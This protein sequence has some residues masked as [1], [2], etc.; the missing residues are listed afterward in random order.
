[1]KKIL[2]LAV[3]AGVALL[4]IWSRP[5]WNHR[6]EILETERPPAP[7]E[8]PASV[9]PQETAPVV[10][11]EPFRVGFS[12]RETG[13]LG[14]AITVD[15]VLEADPKTLP[16]GLVGE[17]AALEYLLRLPS[18]VQLKSDGWA[19]VELPPEEKDDPTGVWNLFERKRTITAPA[20]AAAVEW[21]RES[22]E[23][24]VVRP[25]I[26]WILTMRAKVTRGLNSWQTFG[27]VFATVN[28]DGKVEF[29]TAPRNVQ[30]EQR[31]EANRS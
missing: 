22:V 29:H 27:V 7:A 2:L 4:L 28:G 30:T 24:A 21:A 14:E 3:A 8:S 12:P 17:E 16:A 26:N 23:L 1:M 6:S 10:P 9:S 13:R 19:P 5:I 20:E 11:A 18:G 25:G 15:L 31:V